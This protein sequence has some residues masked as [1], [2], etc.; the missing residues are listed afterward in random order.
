VP[1]PTFPITCGNCGNRV[2]AEVVHL[3]G[4]TEAALQSSQF[5]ISQVMNAPMWLLCPSCGEPSVRTSNAKG[6]GPIVY[7]GALPSQDV[8]H[9]PADVAAA[10]Q[11]ARL[12]HGVGA[13]TAAEIM[14]RK[15]LMHIA[16][17]V[18]GSPPGK[19][20]VEYV[21]HLESQGY[22]LVGLK[23]VVDQVR[24]RGNKA[25][26]ELPASTEQESLTTLKITEHLLAGIYDLPNLGAATVAPVTSA[27][28]APSSSTASVI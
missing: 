25:N 27:G 12:A 5:R 9:M 1:I 16:V 13:Y 17:D 14:C 18:A 19:T 7:P 6:R 20:F 2:G 24:A 3:I 22:I 4:H 21:N 11:E 28:A 23:P 10:W 8:P 26:H 15:I